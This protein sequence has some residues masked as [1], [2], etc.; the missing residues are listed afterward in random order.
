VTSAYD[1][2]A[3]GA[4]TVLAFLIATPRACGAC[5]CWS[6]DWLNLQA[7]ALGAAIPGVFMAADEVMK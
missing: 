3:G 4:S 2:D 1:A 7:K 5:F 6:F